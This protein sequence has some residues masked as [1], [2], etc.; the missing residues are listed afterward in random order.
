M[1]TVTLASHFAGL[2]RGRIFGSTAGVQL[3][4]GVITNMSDQ[5]RV[6]ICE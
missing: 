4:L 3:G 5:C 1:I 6:W 2:C